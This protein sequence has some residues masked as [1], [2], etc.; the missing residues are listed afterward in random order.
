MR[1]IDWLAIT[2]GLVLLFLVGLL[3]YVKPTPVLWLLGSVAW[4]CVTFPAFMWYITQRG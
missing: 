3:W 1:G 2:C 4:A